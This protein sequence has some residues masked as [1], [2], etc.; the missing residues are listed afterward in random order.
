LSDSIRPGLGYW[1]K[2]NVSGYLRL[3]CSPAIEPKTLASNPLG[4][5]NTL[6]VRD[7]AGNEGV[8]YFGLPA[9]ETLH[10]EDYEMPPLPPDPVFD[11]RFTSGGMIH[12]IGNTP[13]DATIRLRSPAYPVTIQWHVVQQGLSTLGFYDPGTGKKVGETGGA[14]DGAIVLNGGGETTLQLRG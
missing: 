12:I 10:E 5:F 1:V 6:T 8:V 7:R 14:A 9:A 3:S 13:R 2:A 4:D 11:V